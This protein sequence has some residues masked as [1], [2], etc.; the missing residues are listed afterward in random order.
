MSIRDCFPG[1]TIMETGQSGGRWSVAEA[2]AAI[3]AALALRA[4][5]VDSNKAAMRFTDLRDALDKMESN[6]RIAPK[7][8]ASA[9]QSLVT[10]GR[11]IKTRSGREAWY[12]LT[13]LPRTQLVPIIAETDRAAIMTASAIGAIGDA[14]ESWAFYGVPDMLRRRLRLQLHEAAVAYRDRIGRVLEKEIR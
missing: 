1:E 5:E 8:V 13:K 10:A 7:T 12:S 4:D 9:L 6:R 14:E 3:V 11:L 2:Q